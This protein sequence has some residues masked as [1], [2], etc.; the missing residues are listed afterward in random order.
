MSQDGRAVLHHQEQGASW[1]SVPSQNDRR[2]VPLECQSVSF[3][4]FSLQWSI[5]RLTCS[6]DKP[7]L[8]KLIEAVNAN[9]KD[10]FDE[11]RRFWGGG[12][13]SQRS[14]ARQAKILRAKEK[15]AAKK[16]AL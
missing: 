9:Y 12:Q 4:L 1:S 7:T 15:E 3:R 11:I 6:E 8:A 10:R 14:Q 16:A 5:K 2:R 13:M